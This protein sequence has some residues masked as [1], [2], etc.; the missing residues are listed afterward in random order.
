MSKNQ[1]I[2]II[3]VGYKIS[4]FIEH[5]IEKED[6][7][8]SFVT[9]NSSDFQI[10]HPDP[11]KMLNCNL[12]FTNLIELKSK[13]S[14][15]S[16]ATFETLGQLFDFYNPLRLSTINYLISRYTTMIKEP[17][18]DYL[19]AWKEITNTLFDEEVIYP[20]FEETRTLHIKEDNLEV[21]I[22]QYMILKELELKK[23]EKEKDIKGKNEII[24]E[25]IEESTGIVDLKEINKMRLC[26]EAVKKIEA[27]EAV[28]IVPTDV[29]STYILFNSNSLKNTLK[30]T[31]GKIAFLSPF[32]PENLPSAVEK[33]ILEKTSFQPDLVNITEL[34]KD[35][36]DIIIINK[37]DSDLVPKLRDTGITV[38]VEDLSASTQES[39]EFLELVLKSTDISIDSI[40]IEPKEKKEG[41]REKL[42][43]LVS[44]TTKKEEKEEVE[45]EFEDKEITEPDIDKEVD[46]QLLKKPEV[47]LEFND[48]VQK[49][50]EES[51]A[52]EAE[53][54]IE[55]VEMEKA[56]PAQL[57]APKETSLEEEAVKA[58]TEIESIPETNALPMELIAK[59]DWSDLEALNMGEHIHSVIDRAL[60]SS[61]AVG[62]EVIFS[63]LLALQSNTSLMGKVL[64]IL[65]GK[66]IK[67]IEL[68]PENRVASVISY[69]AAHKPEYYSKYFKNMLDQTIRAQE[70]NEFRK[71][72]H[73]AALIINRPF[74]IIE[75]VLEEFI[76]EHIGNENINIEEK[77]RRIIHTL[78]I[79]N[80]TL[81]ECLAHILLNIYKDELNKKEPNKR[82]INRGAIFLSAFDAVTVGLSI[83]QYFPK[84]ML[85]NIPEMLI[86]FRLWEGYVT[87]ISS[88]IKAYEEGNY[89][90]LRNKLNG[91]K[92]PDQVQTVMMK[93]KYAK[94][95]SKV[96]SI[97]L[98]IFAE[99]AGLPI[100]KA[101]KM[102]YD[103]ILKGEISA[104]IELV[105]RRLY[106]IK[107][108]TPEEEAERKAHEEA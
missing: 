30:K 101:E 19:A 93:R 94:S 27:A 26:S 11:S 61:D 92:I 97:P 88:I 22:R 76:C 64:E 16:V 2:A 99:Q 58:L 49:I 84:P 50:S 62:V 55:R 102:V 82:I 31:S 43:N 98:E 51:I 42:V 28:I 25:V 6:I 83:I 10:H 20:L 78:A 12:E 21:P 24:E 71:N 48:T 52:E 77:L 44:R 37:K 59:M 103:M 33:T 46:N 34:V 32:W 105:D 100:N 95:I 8:C 63:D 91:Q 40:R 65:M 66:L 81:Q 29:V 56:L 86:P 53:K 90:E 89:E 1:E 79:K 13:K 72:L 9:N 14:I 107:E 106:I 45:D 69:L 38:L 3:I 104:R 23:E 7:A 67:F 41:I 68:K 17:N 87:I 18:K 60:L 73:T 54:E 4:P 35:V 39:R 5:L 70:E 47:S 96:G 36:V 85:E 108:E 57:P 80:P 74:P 75:E 15:D